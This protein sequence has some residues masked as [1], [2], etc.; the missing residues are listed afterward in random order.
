MNLTK[1]K[2]IS[3]IEKEISYPDFIAMAGTQ[4]N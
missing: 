2:K 4:Q 3:E 1:I